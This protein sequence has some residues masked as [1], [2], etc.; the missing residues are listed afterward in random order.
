MNY[1]TMM[2]R[3]FFL[4]ARSKKFSWLC[5]VHFC[6]DVGHALAIDFHAAL[7]HQTVGFAS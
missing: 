3:N 6:L 2:R 7:F 4:P 5:E 1:S